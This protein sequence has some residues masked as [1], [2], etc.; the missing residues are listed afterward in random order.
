[1]QN[2]NPGSRTPN[3]QQTEYPLTNRL[4]F[5]GLSLKLDSTA[6]AYYQQAFSPLDPIDGW[7]WHLSLV[8]YMFVFVN[9]DALARASDFEIEKR[10]AVFL[11]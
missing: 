1:M 11:C 2:S 7:L 3:H 4:S 6:R 10:Q 5:R 8:I 9:A